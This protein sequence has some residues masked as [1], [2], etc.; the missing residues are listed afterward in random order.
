MSK[1]DTCVRIMSLYELV[2]WW[3]RERLCACVCVSRAFMSVDS[4]ASFVD[5]VGSVL[6]VIVTESTKMIRSGGHT[7]SCCQSK[8]H[9]TQVQVSRLPYND[10]ND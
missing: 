2:W 8:C 9:G 3:G 7:K 6:R 5:E 10:I 4:C 1:A